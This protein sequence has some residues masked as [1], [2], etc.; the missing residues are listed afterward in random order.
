MGIIGQ[1]KERKLSDR[2]K[3]EAVSLG[4]CA[5]WTAEWE[6]GTSKDEM[7]EKFVTGL[8]FCIQHNFPSTEV[9]KKD[10]GDVIHKHGVYVGE[11]VHLQHPKIV[12]LNGRC[13]GSI[14][15]G[16]Y[17]AGNI[18]VRHNSNVTIRID[19]H[20]YVHISVYDDAIVNVSC[21]PS[22]KCFIYKY[23]GETKTDGKTIVRD[24]SSK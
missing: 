14:L 4:L 11:E 10:F 5:Q 3:Q 24:R 18:Y 16:G 20:A 1:I 15:C 23:G 12:V 21:A 2:M 13:G 19:G 7:V 8:D 17:D 22:A 9:M 6:N